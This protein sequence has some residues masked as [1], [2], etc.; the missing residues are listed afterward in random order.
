MPRPT[1]ELPFTYTTVPKPGAH[2][3]FLMPNQRVS[4]ARSFNGVVLAH[5]EFLKFFEETGFEYELSAGFYPCTVRFF[6]REELDYFK[7]RFNIASD[8]IGPYSS[9]GLERG[10]PVFVLPFV[11]YN[12]YNAGIKGRSFRGA[13]VQHGEFN[14]FFEDTGF[15]YEVAHVPTGDGQFED[16][17]QEAAP[18]T[19][20]GNYSPI[21]PKHWPVQSV[22]KFQDEMEMRIF[23]LKFGIGWQ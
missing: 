23:M 18:K 12:D 15:R 16:D 10:K 21:R 14:E 7:S 17:W 13:V 20:F 9:Y 19:A 3:Q 4:P 5:D 11:Y 2:S 8:T 22:V 1:Y 6:S